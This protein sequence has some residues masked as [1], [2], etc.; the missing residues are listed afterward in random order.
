MS[1]KQNTRHPLADGCPPLWASGWG[2]D[3]Q[4]IFVE[5]TVGEVIQRLRWVPPGEFPMGAAPDEPGRWDNEG[6]RHRVVLD[7]G[8]WLSDTPCTQALWQAVMED[9]PSYFQSPNRPVESVNWARVNA[10][11]AAIAG[12]IPDLHPVLPTEAQWEYACR[13]GIDAATYAGTMA[14]LG[15]NHAPILDAIAW[16]GGNS[17]VA[18]ELDNGY[19]STDWPEKQYP[20]GRVGTHPVGRKA[21]NPL[22]LYDM[23]GNV[24][25]WCRDGRRDY[26]NGSVTNPMGS[27]EM[28]VK[29]TV[30]GGS[31]NSSA[32][33]AR[34]ASRRWAEPDIHNASL[35][36]RCAVLSSLAADG[37]A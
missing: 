12:R 33:N 2:E 32:R 18:F 35:G 15:A 31:W 9:N 29:R 6:P 5:F 7:R 20:H 25:E 37:G 8:Y 10:F 34:A 23:L 26:G 13:A 27:M 4:G 28:G 36:F 1:V 16:Y 3:R 14:I 22:G 21:P 17:G 11:L 19:D 24:W 30:R